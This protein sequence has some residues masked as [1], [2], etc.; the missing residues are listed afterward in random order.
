MTFWLGHKDFQRK[1]YWGS[2]AF[3]PKPRYKIKKSEKKNVLVELQVV[4]HIL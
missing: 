4:E 2:G 3:P 1:R